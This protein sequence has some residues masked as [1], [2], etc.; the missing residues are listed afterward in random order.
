M[1][2]IGFNIEVEEEGEAPITIPTSI[3]WDFE[4]TY[5]PGDI[6]THN[7]LNWTAQRVAIT[8]TDSNSP[9]VGEVTVLENLNKAPRV[10]SEF[11][12]EY[13]GPIWDDNTLISEIIPTLTHDKLTGSAFAN[14]A[15][16][17]IIQQSGD[18][19]NWDTQSVINF[20]NNGDPIVINTGGGSA[21]GFS[22]EI[23]LPYIRLKFIADDALPTD[24]H[25]YGRTADAGVKY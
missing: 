22:E 11:W 24:L 23:I 25:V 9:D 5:E 20:S 6:V 8:N 14:E 13:R 21:V 1:A 7:G 3:G 18:N 12:S 16:T 2:F 17:L 10:G 15:G 4:T 19:K